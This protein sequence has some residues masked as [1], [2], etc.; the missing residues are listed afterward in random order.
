MTQ[1]VQK[2]RHFKDR[3]THNQFINKN[4][5]HLWYIINPSI[6]KQSIIKII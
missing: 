6:N 1:Q 4:E 2:K 3:H 5:K